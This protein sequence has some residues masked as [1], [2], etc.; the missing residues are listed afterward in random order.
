MPDSSPVVH[1]AQKRRSQ[2]H[3]GGTVLSVTTLSHP[4]VRFGKRPR[5]IALIELEDGARVMG[6]LTAPCSIGSTVRP[7]MRL[8]SINPEGL[9]IYD[10]AY[11]PV[12]HVPTLEEAFPGYILALTGPSGV[13]K[14]AVSRLLVQMFSAYVSPVPIVTTR[15]R[16]KGDDGE[17]R[18]VSKRMFEALIASGEMVAYT[19]IPSSTEERLY[20]YRKGDIEKIWGQE[21]LP[22]VITEMH[23]LQG[24]TQSFGR[25]SLLSFGLL[26]P[27]KSKRAML[28]QLLHRMRTRGRETEE[29]MADR[30]KNAERDLAFFRERKDLFD[31]LLV[32]EDLDGVLA[33]MKERVPALK[34]A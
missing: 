6:A 9:R 25:R 5:S 22:V 3:Q 27:G 32:N 23:L 26:P 31:H 1:R 16:K 12:I 13:G 21:K 34:K 18:Y 14:T 2:K 7:R 4:P 29:Q 24:L 10:V 33:M 17:Y 11:E 19:N 20:G 30:I 28:S 8:S 15:K